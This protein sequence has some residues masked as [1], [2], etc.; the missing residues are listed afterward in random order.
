MTSDIRAICEVLDAACRAIRDENALAAL[1]SIRS[2]T[3]FL[4]DMDT[5]TWIPVEF[6]GLCVNPD[7]LPED[8]K[9]K[10]VCTRTGSGR[11]DWNRAYWNGERWVGNI[12]T[13]EV[14]AWTDIEPFEGEKDA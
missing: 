12:G 9:Y 2:V 4:E 10:L 14:Y 5:I 13:A 11:K 6:N 3:R 1:A 8:D 7:S